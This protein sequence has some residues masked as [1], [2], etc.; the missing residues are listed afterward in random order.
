VVGFFQAISGWMRSSRAPSIR[1]G[2]GPD[3]LPPVLGRA[4]WSEVLIRNAADC[5]SNWYL[6]R[7]AGREVRAGNNSGRPI[8]K[9]GGHVQC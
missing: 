2:Q 9:A 7:D 4:D 5:S 6:E 3:W 1:F 8:D